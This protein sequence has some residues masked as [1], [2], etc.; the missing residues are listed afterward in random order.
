[1][2]VRD[3]RVRAARG[4]IHYNPPA[5]PRAGKAKKAA[6]YEGAADADALAAFL[7]RAIDG[8]EHMT[9]YTEHPDLEAL[10]GEAAAAGGATGGDAEDGSS[11][12]L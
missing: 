9:P 4:E 5:H 7:D 10:K 1:M 2:A 11:E 8:T 6:F 3:A 12:E